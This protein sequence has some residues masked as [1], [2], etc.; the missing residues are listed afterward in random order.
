MRLMQ[1]SRIEPSYTSKDGCRLVWKGVDEDD[2]D[3]VILNKKELEQLVEI[4]KEDKT[5]KVELED[6]ISRIM[7]NS[8]VTQ[9]DLKDHDLLEVK[10]TELQKQVLD[11]AKIPHQPQYVYISPKE[12]HPSIT[13]RKD[14][15][16]KKDDEK[17]SSQMSLIQ[18]I[19]TS[20]LHRIFHSQICLEYS[21]QD[22]Q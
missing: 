7:V 12:F 5:G 16:P 8:D 6:Q 22:V 10:T 2:L 1:F 20:K 9:F 17:K 4:L 15:E 3:T 18:A 19:L 13:I 14:E 21:Q 11:Y